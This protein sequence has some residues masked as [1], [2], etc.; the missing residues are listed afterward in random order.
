MVSCEHYILSL[1]GTKAHKGNTMWEEV[2]QK[3]AKSLQGQERK[4]DDGLPDVNLYNSSFSHANQVARKRNS[5]LASEKNGLHSLS[6]IL[7]AIL[8][9]L[10]STYFYTQS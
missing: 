8:F 4:G 2:G 9:F 6:L 7:S 1:A 5:K 10:L 3:E